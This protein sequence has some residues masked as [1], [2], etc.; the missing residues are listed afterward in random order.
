MYVYIYY[1]IYACIHLDTIVSCKMALY[2][3]FFPLRTSAAY[4]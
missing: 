2:Y 4:E 1:L 3:A